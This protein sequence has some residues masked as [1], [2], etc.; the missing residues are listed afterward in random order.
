VEFL[1]NLLSLGKFVSFI[2]SCTLCIAE[3]ESVER[4]GVI[5]LMGGWLP[6]RQPLWTAGDGLGITE[7]GDGFE[8]SRN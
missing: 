3:D 8:Y 4:E 6:G 5:R 2:A 1:Y 7:D